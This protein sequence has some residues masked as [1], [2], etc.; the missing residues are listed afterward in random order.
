MADKRLASGNIA[1]TSLTDLYAVPAGGSARIYSLVLTNTTANNITVSV[2]VN[3]GTSRLVKTTFIPG[4]SG[5]VRA[6]YEVQALDA[7]D[8]ISLQAGSTD[9]F[10]YLLNGR[11]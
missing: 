10:N 8:T 5:K 6:V 2:Y 3:D 1:S 11:V 4:G 9:S 7:G